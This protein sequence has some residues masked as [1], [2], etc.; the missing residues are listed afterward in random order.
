V[1]NKNFTPNFGL[2]KLFDFI[3]FHHRKKMYK[4]IFCDL[5]GNV[6]YKLLDIG[7]TSDTG[8]SSNAFLRFFP[9]DKIV[10]VSDQEIS[11]ET[12]MKF[13]NVDF[14]QGDGRALEFMNGEF[15]LVFSN[16][17][18]EHVGANKNIE[19]FI[20]EANRVSSSKVILIT[21]N[22]WFPLETHT[23][24]FFLHWLPKKL[25]RKLLIFFGLNFFASEENLNLLTPKDVKKILVAAGIQN[26]KIESLKFFGIP[27]N[28]LIR[29][30][31][32]F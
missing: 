14:R 4:T 6:H 26:Y 19:K 5:D 28:I 8:K 11:F 10:S 16:A 9:K 21:P 17:V 18:L 32:G 20:T 24:I 12:K 7:S 13:P 15:D 22:R 2:N 23:K 27:S 29:I 30:N 3:V 31:K 1:N 25:F